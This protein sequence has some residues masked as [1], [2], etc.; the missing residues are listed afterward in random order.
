MKGILFF[1]R[2]MFLAIIL[3]AL[4][5]FMLLAETNALPELWFC[6]PARKIQIGGTERMKLAENGRIDFEIVVPDSAGLPAKFAGEELASL[7]GEALRTKIPIVKQRSAEKKHAL[8]LGDSELSRKAGLDVSKLT[9]DGFYIRTAGND[10]YIAGRDDKQSDSRTLLS[11]KS[12]K[13][14]PYRYQRGTLY[15]VYDFLE[16]FAGMRFYFPTELGT[17]I[18]KREDFSLPVIDI[19]DRPDCPVR[20]YP[21]CRY[22]PKSWFGTGDP[23]QESNL[24]ALRWRIQTRLLPNCHGLQQLGY[25]KRFGESNPEFFALRKDGTRWNTQYPGYLCLSNPNLRNEIFRDAKSALS[26]EPPEKR[27]VKLV[28]ANGLA[29]QNWMPEVYQ[30]DGFFNVHL[31]DGWSPCHCSECMKYYSRPDAEAG[32][33]VWEMTA[34]I[35]NRIK[36]AGINGYITQMGYHFYRPVP[37]V[38]LPDNVL[39]Q[40][41]FPGAWGWENPEQAKVEQNLIR[42]WNKKLNK[43]VWLWNYY[44]SD[45]SGDV[46]SFPGC[47]QYSPRAIGHYYKTLSPWIAGA[48]LETTHY[49]GAIQR[50][51]MN[52]YVGMKILWDN[53]LDPNQIVEEYYVNM[54]G[55]AAPFMKQYFDE[56]EKIWVSQIRGKSVETPL[57]PQPLKP[58]DY[59]IWENFYSPQKLKDWE[60]LFA[61][62]AKAVPQN[63]LEWKRIE[64]MRQNF[65]IPALDYSK[66]YF[67]NQDAINSLNALAGTLVNAPVIDGKLEEPEWK[68]TSKQYLSKLKFGKTPIRASVRLLKDSENLYIGFE[69]EDPETANLTAGKAED[70]TSEIF[71]NATFEIF[72][73]PSNDRRNLYQFAISPSGSVYALKHPEKRVWGKNAIRSKTFKDDRKW[74]AEIVIPFALLPELKSVFPANFS[75]NRQL[76]GKAACSDLYSWTPY[77][78]RAFHEVDHYG[79]LSLKTKDTGNLVKD[80]D[81]ADLTRIGNTAGSYWTM[82]EDHP[83]S[84]IRFDSENFITGGQSL[85]VKSDAVENNK[86]ALR[87]AYNRLNLKPNTNYR[88]SYFM[89][90]NLAPGAFMTSRVWAGRNFFFPRDSHRGKF[91]WMPFYGEFRT[92]SVMKDAHIGFELHGAG[93]VNID[94]VILK[95]IE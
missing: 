50:D 47:S 75:Y 11:D 94:N 59:E 90:G 42:A 78:R 53:T 58:S 3:T 33:L 17:I 68:K 82:K 84:V 60:A 48:F 65:L 15:G 93:E 56:T 36:K 85:H 83:G 79:S 72:L 10:I 7:L 76:N 92:P 64:F 27:G 57:G 39:V 69:S 21:H 40:L 51:F 30:K 86:I 13:T 12:W 8:I 16:R 29:F 24:N 2:K 73:N 66:K 9:R 41:A 87:I 18:P 44:D 89:R 22:T 46:Y 81:F 37:N 5:S 88:F 95:E 62:A 91:E 52:L 32:E 20:F 43:K 19:M 74:S 14:D 45:D 35:A 54:F 4:A 80:H 38:A 1:M 28:L 49:P 34:E 25:F 63:S 6:P 55:K 31:M 67:K 77:L 71:E 26:G 23:V 70:Q 61:S